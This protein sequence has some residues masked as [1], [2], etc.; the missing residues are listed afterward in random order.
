MTNLLTIN[1]YGLLF[2]LRKTGIVNTTKIDLPIFMFCNG[3][4]IAKG[5]F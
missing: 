3:E 4:A 1:D 5:E 2:F